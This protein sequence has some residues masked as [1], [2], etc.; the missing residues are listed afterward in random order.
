MIEVVNKAQPIIDACLEA[1]TIV[2]DTETS[3]LR[4]WVDGKILAGVAVKP[5][6]GPMFYLPVRHANS[7]NAS[8]SEVHK[9]FK[10]LQGKSWVFHNAK[11][12]M[13]VLW[14]EG[15]DLTREHVY[16]TIVAMRLVSEAE[17][18]YELKKL[19]D[20][21]Y[22]FDYQEPNG[23]EVEKEFKDYLRKHK[24]Y[25]INKDGEKMWRYDKAPA[26]YIADPYV[27]NDLRFTEDLFKRAIL[28][29]ERR[30]LL[31]LFEL[32]SDLTQALFDMERYGFMID[33][34]YIAQERK[35][36]LELVKRLKNECYDMAYEELS[37]VANKKCKCID[38]EICSACR[39]REA[40]EVLE[41]YGQNKKVYKRTGEVKWS[42]PSDYFNVG[43][44][45]FIKK[46]FEGMNLESPRKT[47]TGR[48]S[49]NRVALASFEHPLADKVVKCRAGMSM[50]NYYRI[51]EEMK[52]S[53]NVIHP[54]IRQAGTKTGRC[55]CSDPNLQNTPSGAAVS[56]RIGAQAT[57][58]K[59]QTKI[60][61]EIDDDNA[62]KAKAQRYADI[63]KKQ[64]GF[65]VEVKEEITSGFEAQLFKR[66][67]GAFIPRPGSFLLSVDWQNIEM[68][69]FADYAKEKEM[70]E[71]FRL[72]LDIH[73]LTA[74]SAFGLV[75]DEK[76]NPDLFKW[77]RQMGKQIAFGLLYGMGVRLLAAEI[78][79]TEEEAKVFLKQFF[80]RF[81][82]AKNFI[83]N[84]NKR[85]EIKGFLKNRWGRRRY[86]QEGESFKGVNYLVQ[87]TAA[88]L[89]KDAIVRVF[90]LL[91]P[92]KTQMILTV[93]DEII[94][95]VVWEE[96]EE[97]IP[98]IVAEMEKCDKI[99]CAL[100]CDAEFGPVRWSELIKL[101]CEPCDGK[102][103]VIDIPKTELIEALYENNYALLEKANVT[104]CEDCKGHGYDLSILKEAA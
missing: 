80:A 65:D 94:F 29:I 34:E 28:V 92:Y 86:L 41:H 47:E 62:R 89:M 83:S 6:N 40:R 38:D 19:A 63:G 96:A 75:P 49:W 59:M 17:T 68:R 7:V 30:D 77:V 102:G 50:L 79:R 3:G 66:V 104:N 67:R 44:P 21:Y 1:D 11:F 71:T 18:S 23:S 26:S 8:I 81:K 57:V 22:L 69:I 31:P 37:K 60:R 15:V 58:A 73:R 76:E 46:I 39:A 27:K 2:I 10:A 33:L 82:N 43:N 4:P 51:F 74:R 90:K 72:G 53:N 5:L 84:V 87:G 9:L 14:Q 101:S 99:T 55:S 52:D 20:K 45:H 97:V 88:D 93:H 32:E 85:V 103:V 16:D 13:A 91:K 48:S 78:G 12:D 36:V 64:I 98:L 54:S 95:D 61:Q 100:K 42:G 70:Q 35:V 24:C 25:D 56:T